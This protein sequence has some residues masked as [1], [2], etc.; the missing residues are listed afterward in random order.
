MNTELSIVICT[1]NR[2]AVLEE[3]LQSYCKLAGAMSPSVELIVVDN[4]SSDSTK[5][6]TKKYAELIP[7]LRYIHEPTPGLSY[8]RNTGVAHASGELVSFVDDDIYFDPHWIEAVIDIFK[9]TPDASCMGGKS[10]PLFEAG[11]PAWLQDEH[12]GIYGSTLSGDSVKWMIYPEHPFGLNMVFKRNVFSIVG[13]FNPA[14]G[15]IK[16]NLLSMEETDYFLRVFNKGLKVI[17]CPDAIVQHRIPPD[18]SERQWA[19]SRYYW[20]GISSVVFKQL[21]NPTSRIKC[22]GDAAST[23]LDIMRQV[24]GGSYSPRK[25][26]WHMTSLDFSDRLNVARNIGKMKQLLIECL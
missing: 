16:K 20:Q 26:Y 21:H 3:T 2:A 6:V 4:N 13:S 1:Y 25:I 24:I 14:L 15:R 10:I 9:I 7:G 8:A 18:R 5:S 19:V 11:R 23:A 17:Y 12:L 22:L